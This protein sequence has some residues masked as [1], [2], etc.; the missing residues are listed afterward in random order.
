[1]HCVQKG[2]GG[3]ENLSLIPGNVGA[4]PMQNIGAYGV[5]VKDVVTSVEFADIH[6]GEIER[7]KAE[8][9]EFGY[10]TSV[11]KTSLKNKKFI[12]HVNFK[13]FKGA[14]IKH[15]LRSHRKGIRTLGT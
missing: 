6:T 9:C 5:E 13:T 14:K 4:S 15:Q 2:Y 3:I 12:S 1:M 7:L 8:E 10:R 11:F